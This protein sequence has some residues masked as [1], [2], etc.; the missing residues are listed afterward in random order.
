MHNVY[1]YM[2]QTSALEVE[3]AHLKHSAKQYKR[4]IEVYRGQVGR[5][6]GET[7]CWYILKSNVGNS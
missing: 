5:Q 6:F 1:L 7:R 3:I 2:L 4:L